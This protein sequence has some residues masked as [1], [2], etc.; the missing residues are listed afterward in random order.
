MHPLLLA[1][2]FVGGLAGLAF[3]TL[4]FRTSKRGWG[5]ALLSIAAAMAATVAWPAVLIFI[6]FPG[7]D[8]DPDEPG[9]W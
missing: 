1:Y 7:G 5:D 4:V 2:M 6:F 8:F 3:G 9:T